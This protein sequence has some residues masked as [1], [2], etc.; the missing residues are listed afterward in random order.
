MSQLLRVLFLDPIAFIVAC[1]V[2]GVAASVLLWVPGSFTVP[3]A[4]IFDTIFFTANAAAFAF[5]PALVAIILAEAFGW[6]SV[7]YW[8]AVGG[9][10]GLSGHLLMSPGLMP[11]GDRMATLVG[12]G[13]LGGLVYWALAGWMAGPAARAPSLPDDPA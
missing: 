7:F 3:E 11:A 2:A 10:I 6:R 8:L 9:A 1:I 12:T 4:V 5:A 13:L